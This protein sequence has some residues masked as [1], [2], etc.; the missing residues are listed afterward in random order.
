MVTKKKVKKVVKKT[1]KKSLKKVVNKKEKKIS[2]KTTKTK[3]KKLTEK[4]VGRISHFFDKISVAVVE[5]TNSLKVGDKIAIK[6]NTTNFEQ[7]IESMQLEHQQVKEAKKG[8]GIGLKVKDLVRL[9][10]LV[11]LLK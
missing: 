2:K 8:Q 3:I 5:L 10:D 7:K 6:G 9:N 4:V 11:Y 1:A